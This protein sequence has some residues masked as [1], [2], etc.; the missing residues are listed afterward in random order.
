MVSYCESRGIGGIVVNGSIRDADALKDKVFPIYTKGI[1]PNGPF[2]NGPGEINTPISIGGKVVSPGDIVV[3]DQDGLVIIQPENA[4]KIAKLAK[5]VTKKEHLLMKKIKEDG[6]YERPWVNK[7]LSE[8]GCE[9][10]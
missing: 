6:I 10:E 1:T 7:V 4:E 8:I 9:Y 2:K 3:G 5:G